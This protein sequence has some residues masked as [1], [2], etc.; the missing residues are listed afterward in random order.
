MGNIQ[1]TIFWIAV[2]V[3]A[4]AGG[5]LSIYFLRFQHKSDSLG[6]DKFGVIWTLVPVGILVTLLVFTFQSMQA[7]P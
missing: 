5:L 2:V 7:T 6:I 1:V 3:S 4:A